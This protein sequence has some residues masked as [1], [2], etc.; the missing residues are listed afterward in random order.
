MPLPPSA[1][2]IGIA[3][4]GHDLR[5][6]SGAILMAGGLIQRQAERGCTVG[7][8]RM[9]IGKNWYRIKFRSRCAL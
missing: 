7:F 4:R 1:G 5:S 2:C 8:D 9:M 6:P 3:V